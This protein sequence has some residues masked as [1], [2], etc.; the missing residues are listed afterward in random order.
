M[1]DRPWLAL[2]HGSTA[3]A[4][5]KLEVTVEG[6][7][8]V[9]D[10]GPVIL[11]ARHYHHLYDGVVLVSTL[12]RPT[13]IVVGLDWITNRAG[14]SM[15]DRL[16]RAAGWPVVVRHDASSANRAHVMAT[17]RRGVNDA[18]NVLRRGE[19]LLVFPEGYPTIDPGYT[20]KTDDDAFLPFQAG[21]LR[22]ARLAKRSGIDAPLVPVGLRYER[23]PRWRVTLA[24]G[25]PRRLD[26]E[27]DDATL[28]R[29]IEA[30]VKALS[31]YPD[32]PRPD[33]V[34]LFPCP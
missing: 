21:M 20:P 17:M 19:V 11:A 4:K 14:Y 29:A 12:N 27:D 16:C 6:L 33:N 23:G 28:L 9:P 32:S 10:Q 2:H 15:M 1:P 34:R 25:A 30:D 7:D 13:R 18:I 5:R 3:L 8:L 31:G 22:I 26:E 24:F